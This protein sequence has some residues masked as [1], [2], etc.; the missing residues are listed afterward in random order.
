MRLESPDCRASRRPRFPVNRTA[1]VTVR[2]E[3]GWDRLR[4]EKAGITIFFEYP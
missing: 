4:S 2:G 1:V 3:S